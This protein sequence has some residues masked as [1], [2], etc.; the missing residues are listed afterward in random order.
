MF[1]GA[2]QGRARGDDRRAGRGGAESSSQ[3]GSPALDLGDLSLS[4]ARALAYPYPGGPPGR[5]QGCPIRPRTHA[6]SAATAVEHNCC[7]HWPLAADRARAGRP[8]LAVAAP[9]VK[10]IRR[11]S[12]G[13]SGCCCLPSP[14]PQAAARRLRFLS[15]G[16]SS[17]RNASALASLLETLAWIARVAVRGQLSCPVACA[18]GPRDKQL[19]IVRLQMSFGEWKD[20]PRAFQPSTRSARGADKQAL[21]DD[22][23]NE[24]TP[25]LF[26][27]CM[28]I[29]ACCFF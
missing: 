27:T 16:P 1:T 10:S 15:K 19:A 21:N 2:Q 12:H 29:R 11:Q 9:P 14:P 4:A 23:D 17:V 8:Q 3:Q 5:G 20:A 26:V 7:R 22:N 28:R 13:V 24:Y 6:Q 18:R 25:F